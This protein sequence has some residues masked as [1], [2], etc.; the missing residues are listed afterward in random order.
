MRWIGLL[1]ALVVLDAAL[2]FENIWP[3]PAVWWRGGLS[4]ELAVCILALLI[5][6]RRGSAP[7]KTLTR[8]LGGVWTVLAIGRYADVTVPAL[9]GRPINLYWDLRF[10]PDVIAM[11][12]SVAAASL[13]VASTAGAVLALA[14]I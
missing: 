14:I 5:A 12:T 4:I 10:I 13:I 11:V 3:T 8:V 7:S 2:T 1:S 9:Y 6:N